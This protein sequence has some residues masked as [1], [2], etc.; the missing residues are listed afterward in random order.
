MTTYTEGQGLAL[1]FALFAD[2]TLLVT[3]V[4]R[5]SGRTH[6]M[7]VPDSGVTGDQIKAYHEGAYVQKAFPTLGDEER[8]FIISGTTPSEWKALFGTDGGD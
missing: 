4:S 1:G 7:C 3:R 2:G 8:E 5:A 6:Q